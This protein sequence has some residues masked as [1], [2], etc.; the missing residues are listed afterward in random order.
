M[1]KDGRKMIYYLSA[2]KS[3]QVKSALFIEH[4]YNNQKADQ[5]ASQIK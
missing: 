1:S 2:V 4:I 5:S 3:S